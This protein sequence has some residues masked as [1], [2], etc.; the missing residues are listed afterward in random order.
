[1]GALVIARLTF[2]EAARSRILLAALAMG[3]AFL[4]VFGLGFHYVNQ[5]LRSSQNAP[6]LLQQTEIRSFLTLS[7]LYAV[8]FLTVLM[9][10]LTSVATLSGEIASGTIQSLA[11]KPIARWEIVAGKW[12]G[13][14][15]LLT[16]YVGMMAGGVLGVVYLMSGYQPPNLAYGLLYLWANAI[17]MLNLTLVGGAALSTLA[18][19]VFVFGMFGIAFIG[20]WIEQIGSILQNQ[21]AVNMGIV[22]SLILPSEALWKRAVFE[23]QSPLASAMGFSPFSASTVPSPLMMMYAVLYM[24]VAFGLAIRIFHHRDL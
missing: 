1:M 23:M 14:G 24:L 18:N 22:T 7:G 12:L 8:N 11:T 19:G 17:L 2:Q 10:V 20:G 4:L 5:E 3:L 6:G 15:V 13:Y 9:A 16:L 21:T